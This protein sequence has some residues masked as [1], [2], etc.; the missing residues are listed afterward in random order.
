MAIVPQHATAIADGSG[1]AVFVFPAVPQGETWCGTLSIPKAP[2]SAIGIVTA[3]GLEVGSTAGPGSYGPYTVDY[4]QTLA[5]SVSGLVAGVQY[6]AVWHADSEGAKFSTYP[7]PITP[8]VVSAVSGTVDVAN[9]PAVQTVDGTVTADQGGAPWSVD[10]T[11]ATTPTLGSAV[12]S[13]QTT[14][15]GAA[16]A[17]PNHTAVQGVVLSA[18]STNAGPISVGAAGVTAGSGMILSPGQAPTPVLPVD[19][20]DVLH[21]IGSGPDVVSFLVI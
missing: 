10:G 9:F 1:D 2:S 13:G 5:L 11:V 3:G 19:N 14:M 8:T 15:T 4:S 12:A 6:Q 7:G 17:L 21:A 18:P 16:V 20:S